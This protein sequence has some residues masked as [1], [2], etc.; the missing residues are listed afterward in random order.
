[1]SK[2]LPHIP[3]PRWKHIMQSRDVLSFVT[4]PISGRGWSI[5]LLLGTPPHLIYHQPAQQTLRYRPPPSGY[6]PAHQCRDDNHCF[7][8]ASKHFIL[9]EQYIHDCALATSST[10][11]IQHLSC[12]VRTC[13]LNQSDKSS[14]T[15]E[16]KE[17]DFNFKYT[18][19]SRRTSNVLLKTNN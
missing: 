7:D 16:P 9:T 5:G 18:L 17:R 6:P 12:M 8:I 4:Q 19:A 1:M 2:V 13:E 3:S 11:A 14:H 15:I 10:S